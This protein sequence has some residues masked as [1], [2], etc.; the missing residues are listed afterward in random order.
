M[1]KLLAFAVTIFVVGMAWAWTT[2]L[3]RNWGNS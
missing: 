3:M 1:K 2:I